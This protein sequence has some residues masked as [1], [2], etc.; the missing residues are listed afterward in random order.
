MIAVLPYEL[1]VDEKKFIQLS[2]SSRR[3][4]FC[5][6]DEFRGYL[7]VK[8]TFCAIDHY[9]L[10][11]WFYHYFYWY[12]KARSIVDQSDNGTIKS[13]G[14]FKKCLRQKI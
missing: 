13:A 6:N 8:E 9:S 3:L 5:R 12:L 10:S 11:Y 4:T 1:T 2:Q 7:L 14:H